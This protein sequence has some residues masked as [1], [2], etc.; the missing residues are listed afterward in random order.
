[1]MFEE[2]VRSMDH[3]DPRH[4]SNFSMDLEGFSAWL[5]ANQESIMSDPDT[6][7]PWEKVRADAVEAF[8][9]PVSQF[10][11]LMEALGEILNEDSGEDDDLGGLVNVLSGF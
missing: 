8:Q 1:M 6:T 4:G 3:T 7:E 10:Q 11:A 5:D 9:D 2:E